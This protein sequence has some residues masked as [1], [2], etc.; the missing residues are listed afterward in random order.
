MRSVLKTCQL[1]LKVKGPVFVGSGYEIQ[2]K[3]YILQGHKAGVVNPQKLFMLAKKKHL[4]AE[5]ERFMVKDTREDLKHWAMRNHISTDEMQRCMAYTLNAGD[6]QLEK[7]K[8]QIMACMKNPY[9]QPYIPGSSIKGMLRTILLC[10]EIMQNPEKYRRHAQQIKQDLRQQGIRRDRVLAGNIKSIEEETFHILERSEKQRDAVNDCM[11]GII[12]SDSEPLSTEDLILC[13]K[14]EKHVDGN[15]K[16]IN[17]LRECLKPG[18]VIRCTLTVDESLWKRTGKEF[19]A[20]DIMEAV[21][22][23]SERYQEAFLSKFTGN[24]IIS[25]RTVFLG[26]GSGFVSK[27]MIY[28]LFEGREAVAV[29]K[30]IFEKTKVPREHKHEKDLL[31]GVSPH[32]LK[33]TRYQGKEYMMGQCEMTLHPKES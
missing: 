23:F 33:C 4:E 10:D 29:T 28:S 14:W 2:K 6:M 22:R 9:G 11:A 1:E 16:T 13:Q 24:H 26:G 8:M 21:Q 3:E 30:D 27:T 7:G 12:V 32:I 18:K 19:R 25:D 17:L 20:E 31:Y 5:L 15:N